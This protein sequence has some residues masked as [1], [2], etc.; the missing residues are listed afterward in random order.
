MFLQEILKEIEGLSGEAP[1]EEELQGVQNYMNGS[2]VRQN[3]SKGGII[4]QLSFVRLHG[5]DESYLREYVKNVL[6]V[7]PDQVREMAEKYLRSD[8]LTIVVVGDRSKILGQI[9]GFGE[10]IE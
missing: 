10:L 1:S 9:R 8:D 3:A 4:G 5:L 6:A 7:E 2:F